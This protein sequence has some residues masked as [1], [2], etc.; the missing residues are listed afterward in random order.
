[1]LQQDE[2][3]D[4]VIATGETHSRPRVPRAGLRPR[5]ASTGRSYVE[6]DPRYFR[7]AEVDLLLGDASKARRPRLEAEGHVLRAGHADGRRR[8]GARRPRAAAGRQ[9]HRRARAA[10]RVTFDRRVLLAVPQFDYGEAARGPSMEVQFWLPAMEGL[11]R[12][13]D[14]LPF[15]AAMKA[16]GCLD[17]EL[18]ATVERLQPDLVIFSAFEG[19]DA[20]AT[21]AAVRKLTTTAAFFWDDHWRFDIFSSQF[22]TLYD[23]VITT[24]PTAVPRYRALGGSPILAEHA[25]GVARRRVCPGR[26][27]ERVPLRRLVRRRRAPVAEMARRVARPPRR[28]RIVGVPARLAGAAGSASRRWTRSSA[29]GIN[30]N[31]SEL[32]PARHALPARRPDELHDE[33]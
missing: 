19:E 26:G 18:L 15:D 14:L 9:R 16:P 7:P 17:A 20:G 12:E 4:Y 6:I 25:P 31:V 32:A 5:S 3:D 30:L 23:F 24:E 33:P 2:P 10:R 22:A 8:P 28:G 21:L 13:L 27:R 11:V 29:A 1:M